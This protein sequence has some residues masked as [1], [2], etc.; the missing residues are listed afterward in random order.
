MFTPVSTI[1]LVGFGEAGG[2]LG[3]ELA[4][5][6]CAVRAYDVLL[7]AAETRDAMLARI[8]A[9][10]V[11]PAA[12]LEA[13][14]R[15]AKLVVSV[16]TATSAAAVAR[17]A[18]SLLCEGQV[19]LDLNSVSPDTKR[20]NSAA[21]G[22]SGALYADV[23]VM[24]PVPPQRL[25]VPMLVCGPR[26]AELSG[27]LN[28]LGFSTKAVGETVGTASAIKMCRSVVIKGLEALAVES[29]LAARHYG[30][31]EAVLASL[32][33]TFPSMGWTG[34]QPDYLVS[35]VAEHGRRRAAELREVAATLRSAGITPWMAEATA[36]RQDALVDEMQAAGIRYERDAE[37]S[38]RELA[39]GLKRLRTQQ[40]RRGELP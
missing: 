36:A 21:V 34:G 29:L 35:R 18:G 9:A 10:G 30:A 24:A 3:A 22:G 8:E 1:A 28:G 33:A 19:F 12:S 13:A 15:G 38:W 40:A 14:V 5:R 37:F 11:D 6:G 25:A 16:V 4:T 27:A 2:I 17:E 7:D 31:E 23:A 26:A 20:A 39:D 32:A